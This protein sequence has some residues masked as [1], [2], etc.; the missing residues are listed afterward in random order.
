MRSGLWILLL[1]ILAGI[2][3]GTLLRGRLSQPAEVDDI[4]ALREISAME[5][6]QAKIERLEHFLV[7]YPESEYRPDAFYMIAGTMLN[8]IGDTSG[9]VLFAERTL[10]EETEPETQALMYY[11]LYGATAE[12]QPEQAYLYAQRLLQSGIGVAWVYNYIAFDYAEKGKRLDL[13]MALADRAIEF[14]ESAEDSSSYLDTRGWARYQMRDYEQ[15]L[16]DLEE[17]TR[18]APEPSAEI[19]EHLGQAQL[20]TGRV[21]E[22][23]QTFREVLVMGE[24][25]EARAQAGDIMNRKGYTLRQRDAFEAALWEERMARA[26]IIE[27]FTL[28]ALSGGDYEYIPENS[29]VSVLNFF[30]PT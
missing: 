4:T 13:A 28:P 22:A 5:D 15:A 7:D 25:A 20:K 17:A 10:Q 9:M 29:S 26:E 18:L 27:P 1:V 2:V 12:A 23:F 24:Y 16:K 6:P 3:A 19:L 21:D 8:D 14:A 30:S 11:R